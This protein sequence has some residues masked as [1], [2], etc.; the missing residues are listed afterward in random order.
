VFVDALMV[1][2]RDNHVVSSKSAYIGL[3]VD[4]DGEKHVLGI[5]IA[6]TPLEAPGGPGES[7]P[8]APTERS[9]TVS[10]HSARPIYRLY[11]KS[12]THAQCA[13][14]RGCLAVSPSHH[15]RTFLNVLSR[16][17]FRLAQRIR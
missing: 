4:A 13:N 7:H 6:K 8:R 14:R 11:L 3:G 5:W 9:V 17:Y 15:L 16:L 2:V 1:K 12:V 10:R